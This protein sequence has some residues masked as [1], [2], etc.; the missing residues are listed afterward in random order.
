MFFV[1]YPNVLYEYYFQFLLGPFNSQEELK[2]ML[3][4]NFGV[5]NKEHYG[6]LWYFLERS[7]A[8]CVVIF[9][10]NTTSDISKFLYV[11]S[12]A[13]RQVK[14]IFW[15]NLKYQVQI[16]LLFGYTTTHK[17]F[18]IFTYRY[19]K[20]GWNA[21][22]LSQS[23]CRIFSCSSIN[24]VI[25]DC[26]WTW[27]TWTNHRSIIRV[28]AIFYAPPSVLT[29]YNCTFTAGTTYIVQPNLTASR[30]KVCR[31]RSTNCIRKSQLAANDSSI[32]YI[33][34]IITNSSPVAIVEYLHSSFSIPASFNQ[35]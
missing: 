30:T 22:A 16:M 6:M 34:G 8:W 11:F 10:I 23:N 18:V 27:L 32:F 31:V 12:R 17:G 20:L 9:G 14:L 13:V 5:T 2:T 15:D 25:E 29:I 24:I 26:R 1:C 3:L 35:S 33:P 4:Q 7:K 21:T 28:I 19:F